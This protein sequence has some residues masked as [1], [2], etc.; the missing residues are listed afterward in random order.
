VARAGFV[1]LLA[2]AAGVRWLMW[3][4]SVTMFNDGPEFLALARA[5]SAGD[6]GTVVSHPFHPLYPLLV[7]AVH[8][9]G[10]DWETAAALIGVAGG[11]AGVGFLFL[12]LRDAFGAPAAWI[13]AGLV[14]VHSRAV[15]YASDVQS[16]GLYLGLF[17]AGVFF[18]WR[19]FARRSPGWGAAA[20]V[21]SGLAYLTRPEGLGLAC[22]LVS[23]AVLEMLR[24]NW[25]PALTLRWAT[26]TALAALL[27]VA[28][29]AIAIQQHAGTWSLTQ[30]KELTR[31]VGVA[32]DVAAAPPP[33]G[34]RQW[35]GHSP[36]Y[37]PIPDAV[38]AGRL[39]LDRGEDG[40]AVDRAQ[41]PSRRVFASARMLWRTEKSA[42]RYGSLV[43]LL[44]GL[45]FVRGRPTWRA[46]YVGAIAAAYTVVLF[47]L[48][49]SSGY[50][51]RR[52]ALPPLLPLFGY[53]GLGAIAIG[54]WIARGAER[55]GI[56]GLRRTS[57][58]VVA[59]ALAALIGIG[60]LA[61]QREPRR[62]DEAAA[63]AA[64]EW[65]RAHGEPAPLATS[66]LRLG[67]YA[68]MP[69]VPLIRVDDAELA[70]LVD[71]YLEEARVRYVLL[72]DPAE[73]AAIE[74]IEGARLRPLHTVRA[75]GR[76]ARVFERVALT[77]SGAVR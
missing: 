56:R 24:G 59:A 67:Y 38:A 2:L 13:G 37:A 42:F 35:T 26:A 53:V 55:G 34:K 22:V 54:T 76:E 7:A 18:G 69:Y 62:A 68:G 40:M 27:C 32:P 73:V 5:A 52:H 16:D 4:R 28:P 6:F 14:A 20:G 29:Y 30:K 49:L 19:A 8:G 60:E 74:R 9:L 47:G 77:A 70:P 65:L 63:R 1:A 25:R 11:T 15:E 51:S 50:V 58:L 46:F 31:L 23:L 41:T 43:L 12:F 57:P 39:Q 44:A 17:L 10:F 66:R 33:A 45:V 48:T 75:G 36:L 72:D 3:S 64:A 21:A 61:T 71:P